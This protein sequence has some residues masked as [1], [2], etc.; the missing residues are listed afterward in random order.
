MRWSS[1]STQGIDPRGLSIRA[2]GT[3][4]Q[5][6][7]GVPSEEGAQ[8]AGDLALRVYGFH[9]LPPRAGVP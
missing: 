5:Q 6:R 7:A 4:L 3:G 8:I 9:P 2:N 1:P